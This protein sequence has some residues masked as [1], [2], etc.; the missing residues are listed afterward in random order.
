ML[1]LF[2]EVKKNLHELYEGSGKHDNQ[3]KYRREKSRRDRKK[4]HTQRMDAKKKNKQ[5]ETSNR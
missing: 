4:K 2:S 1:S 3:T 5:K